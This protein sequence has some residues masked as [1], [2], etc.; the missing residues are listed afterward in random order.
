MCFAFPMAEMCMQKYK[1]LLKICSESD[2]GTQTLE[3]FFVILFMANGGSGVCAVM[4]GMQCRVRSNSDTYNNGINSLSQS[5]IS[6]TLP[7]THPT[8]ST[9]ICA[10]WVCRCAVSFIYCKL[11]FVFY[12]WFS[13]KKR[14]SNPTYTARNVCIWY[15]NYAH[16]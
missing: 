14:N 5:I 2:R 12:L 7:Y 6:I 10:L 15:G 3:S 16:K 13:K 8:T 11:V 9:P 4:F 1:N